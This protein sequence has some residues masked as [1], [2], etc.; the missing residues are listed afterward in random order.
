MAESRTTELR[1]AFVS[2]VRLVGEKE[3][4]RRVQDL[5]RRAAHRPPGATNPGHDKE[6][7]AM[8][9]ILIKEQPTISIAQVGRDIHEAFR[10]R[11]TATADS[12]EKRIRRL[13]KQRDTAK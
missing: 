3:A 13:M 11:Y 9:D 6:L 1:A 4:R 10:D 8:V 5:L 12:V 7:L 2:L